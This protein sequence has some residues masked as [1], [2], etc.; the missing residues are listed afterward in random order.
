MQKT[1]EPKYDAVNGKLVNRSTGIA[2]PDDEPVFVFRAKDVHA[3]EALEAY[4]CVLKP[5]LHRDVICQRIA[6][7]AKFAYDNPDRMKEP[8]SDAG[9]LAANA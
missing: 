3:R 4:A 5:G 6:D 2:I 8:D 9:T 1:Q 7:F